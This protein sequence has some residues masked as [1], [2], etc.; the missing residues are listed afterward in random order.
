M[1]RFMALIQG[2][3]DLLVDD[4][5]HLCHGPPDEELV[6]RLDPIRRAIA[7]GAVVRLPG[8]GGV[9]THPVCARCAVALEPAGRPAIL[10]WRLPGGGILTRGGE[11]IPGASDA[12]PGPLVVAAA[13]RS[14]DVLLRVIHLLKFSRVTCLIESLAEAIAI[15]TRPATTGLSRPVLVA[16]P[17]DKAAIR[18]R[19]FNQSERIA[20][21][22]GDRWGCRVLADALV[23]PRPTRAQS[24]TP[25]GERLINV[26]GAFVAG[27]AGVAGRDVVLI[28]D[29]VTTGATAAVAAGV[30]GSAGAES[31][32]VV[33]VGQAP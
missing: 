19:G 10:G 23:K 2:V 17:M 8:V 15:A 25:R 22:L 21:A 32:T 16:V 6:R 4:V 28:D 27:P 12:S 9:I 5:C 3:A 31:V 26:R 24:L 13:F 29:L 30:L 11:L 7:A 18:R 14:N 33:C 1:R 20:S